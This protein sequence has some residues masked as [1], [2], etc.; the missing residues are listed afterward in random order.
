MAGVFVEFIFRG[1]IAWIVGLIVG[2][3]A[4]GIGLILGLTQGWSRS[5]GVGGWLL[6]VGLA[7]AVL[8]LIFLI[9]SIATKGRSD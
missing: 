4:S 9:A 7:I 2:L 6:G 8:C 5:G 3:L 1:R